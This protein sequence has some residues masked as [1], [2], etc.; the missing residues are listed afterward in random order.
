MGEHGVYL[1]LMGAL[2]PVSAAIS[3]AFPVNIVK[4]MEDSLCLLLLS[5]MPFLRIFVTVHGVF[6]AS[7]AISADFSVNICVC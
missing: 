2:K 6:T 4:C 3:A 7:S 5:V 1:E